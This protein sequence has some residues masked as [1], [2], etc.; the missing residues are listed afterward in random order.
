[1]SFE[2][3][4]RLQRFIR[5]RPA[6]ADT[7]LLIV[8]G[9]PL[10]PREALEHLERRE[11]VEQV[12][13]KMEKL[14]LAAPIIQEEL[15]LLTEEHYRRL[16]QLPPPRIAIFIMSQQKKY[17]FTLE[18]CLEEVE[19]RTPFGKKLAENHQKL[20]LQMVEWMQ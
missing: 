8:E 19:K 14:R 20:I 6:L 1:M 15:W 18:E 5:R 9:K 11:M 2:T 3:R 17:R 10:S 13:M 7:P 12:S 16:L 4:Q